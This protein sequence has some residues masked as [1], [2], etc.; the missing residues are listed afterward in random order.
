M[1]LLRWLDRLE[2]RVR[3]HL[4]KRPRLYALVA[5]IAIVLF[6]RGVWQLADQFDF[7]TPGTS[8]VIAVLLMLLTGTFVSFFIGGRLLISGLMA[9]KRLD[10]KTAEEIKQEEEDILRLRETI[11]ELRKDISEI[12]DKLNS[13]SSK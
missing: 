6:W 12:K 5:G 10:E 8:I 3:H 11:K 7:L 2:D 9:D 1:K 4:S 13:L